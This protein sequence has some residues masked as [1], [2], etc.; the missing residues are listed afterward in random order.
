M[1]APA[2]S[3][4]PEGEA[5]ALRR[6]HARLTERLAE[7]EERIEALNR[8]GIALSSERDVERLLEKILAESRRFSRSEAGSLYLLENG[9]SEKRLRFKLAQ[10]DAVRFSF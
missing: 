7:S 5:A 3:L 8:I 2:R 10:N 4:E 1:S 9:G 6:E